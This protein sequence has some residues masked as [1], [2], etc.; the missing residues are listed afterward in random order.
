MGTC[1]QEGIVRSWLFLHSLL[2]LGHEMSG[3]ATPH[4]PTVM[5]LPLSQSWTGISKA[6]SQHT[7]Y[8]RYP[9]IE[10]AG[11]HKRYDDWENKPRNKGSMDTLTL[12]LDLDCNHHPQAVADPQVFPPPLPS[13]TYPMSPW[14][15]AENTVPWGKRSKGEQVDIPCVA[16]AWCLTHGGDRGDTAR[17]AMSVPSL[18]SS[19]P[20]VEEERGGSGEEPAGL[21][22][23]HE[24]TPG[25]KGHSQAWCGLLGQGLLVSQGQ[26]PAQ[27]PA[28]PPATA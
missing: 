8:L 2:L 15:T 24:E 12:T 17:L 16:L 7:P 1:P 14:S 23:E 6:L 20:P 21:T 9:T 25:S 19:H 27:R 28:P 11:E 4:A 3:S 18:F 5:R 10:T 13:R 26:G 22:R